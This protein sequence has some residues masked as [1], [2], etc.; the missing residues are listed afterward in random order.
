M[1]ATHFVSRAFWLNGLKDPLHPKSFISPNHFFAN[2]P[3]I[4]MNIF[5]PAGVAR[6]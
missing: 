1:Y 2:P 3:E 5:A 6:E 4:Q